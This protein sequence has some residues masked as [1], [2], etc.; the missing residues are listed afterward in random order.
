M[1]FKFCCNIQAMGS[2]FGINNMKAQ[3]HSA[4]YEQ[5]RLDVVWWCGGTFFATLDP[6]VPAEHH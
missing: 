2:E 5:F 1:S 3:T 4:L 6:V